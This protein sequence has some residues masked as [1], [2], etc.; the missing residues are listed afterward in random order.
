MDELVLC[1]FKHTV[2]KGTV[3]VQ[4]L[5]DT[6]S[7]FQVKN[8]FYVPIPTP[9]SNLCHVAHFV[10]L[11]VFLLRVKDVLFDRHLALNKKTCRGH[12]YMYAYTLASFV[13]HLL[14]FNICL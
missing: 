7:I 3:Q 8:S 11:L 6:Q 14:E 13:C 1:F 5:T 4:T 12:P 9:F 10:H 2:E